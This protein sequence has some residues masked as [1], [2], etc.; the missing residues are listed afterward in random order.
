MNIQKAVKLY[1][2]Y[3]KILSILDDAD[4]KNFR[5]RLFKYSITTDQAEQMRNLVDEL[6]DYGVHLLAR[7]NN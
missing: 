2:E 6:E 3:K 7:E 5:T 4:D 1:K